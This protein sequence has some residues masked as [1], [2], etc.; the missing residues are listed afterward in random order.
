M[1]EYLELTIDELLLDEDNPRLG[2]VSSQSEALEMLVKLN[3]SHFR[4]LMISIRD[5]GLDPGDNLYVIEADDEDDF[6]VLEGNRRLSAMMVL[7]N[8]DI[9]DGTDV[10]VSTKKS[11]ARAAMGFDRDLVEPIRCV[12][13]GSREEAND[14]I[15]RRHTGGAE[16]EGRITWGPTEVQRFT[17]D[18]SILDVIDFVGRNAAYSDEEWAS[19]KSMIESRKSSTLSRM[20]DSGPA[21]KHLAIS[22]AAG[23]GEKTPMLGSDPAWALKVLKRII[24][25][26]RDG[27][28]DSRELNKASDIEDYFKGL[29]TSLQPKKG[30]K[31]TLVAFREIN[32]K[33]HG[34]NGTEAGGK[35][36][37]GKKSGVPR[38]RKSLA[39]K[40]HPF[41]PP[42]SPKGEQLLREAGVLDANKFKVSAAF[43]LRAYLELAI[44]QYM[45]DNGL[46]KKEKNKDGNMVDLAMSTRVERVVEDMRTKKLWESGDLRGFKKQIVNTNSPNSLQSLNDFVHNKFQIPTGD[47]LRSGW[48]S[49]VPV[50]IATFGKV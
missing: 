30:K 27:V 23:A 15:Y 47:A 40:K 18:R 50:F 48:D 9:L 26:V 31:P 3:Q 5:N 35:K 28:V 37:K 8:A 36:A 10:S 34:G 12:Q 24:E 21:K 49:A 45:D 20:I 41:K 46:P 11:L 33:S 19:T 29:P 22:I 2:A 39:P 4:N 44:N 17:G 42:N 13:F 43:V 25:D 7:L 32:L 38:Q 16:G 14:W 6:I 1:V